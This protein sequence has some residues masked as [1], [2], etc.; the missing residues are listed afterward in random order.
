MTLF[1]NGQ[2]C[3][4][5]VLLIHILDADQMTL[6]QG[7]DYYDRTY[8][9]ADL[10][11]AER[12]N[13]VWFWVATI[14]YVVCLVFI[15]VP[16]INHR[17]KKGWELHTKWQT[18]KSFGAQEVKAH[19][20]GIRRDPSCNTDATVRRASIGKAQKMAAVVSAKRMASSSRLKVTGLS[21]KPSPGREISPQR[22]SNLA[23]A[24]KNAPTG[25]RG[26]MMRRTSTAGDTS[27][28]AVT[29]NS[30]SQLAHGSSSFH[31]DGVNQ[32]ECELDTL[33]SS[34]ARQHHH[35]GPRTSN[36]VRSTQTRSTPNFNSRPARSSAR[37]QERVVE[38]VVASDA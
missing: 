12:V 36:F 38:S 9:D 13:T 11:L 35:V 34:L 24:A 21:P 14:T 37:N 4:V 19:V 1:F 17:L 15:F 32:S 7:N 26:R 6:T 16:K 22:S 18:L 25:F 29:P 20:A 28:V 23:G 5:A 8:D 33:A 10:A 31:I 27:V 2:G 3:V 30:R